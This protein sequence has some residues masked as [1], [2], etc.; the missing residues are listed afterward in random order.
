VKQ[1]CRFYQRD[2]TDNQHRVDQHHV[3]AVES[4]AWR[5]LLL[6]AYQLGS[7]VMHQLL[8]DTAVHDDTVQWPLYIPIS[9]TCHFLGSSQKIPVI[10]ELVNSK[11]MLK[12][13]LPKLMCMTK[14]QNNSLIYQLLMFSTENFTW[15]LHFTNF[16]DISHFKYCSR[17]ITTGS[18]TLQEILHLFQNKTC[19]SC[20]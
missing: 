3:L 5:S 1:G 10:R 13:I 14:M 19:H 7:S 2:L 6:T 9:C 20:L 4:E 8:S 18:H 12:N 17:Q 15:D 16:T 11:V